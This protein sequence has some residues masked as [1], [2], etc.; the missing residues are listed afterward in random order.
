MRNTLAYN[1]I[2]ITLAASVISGCAYVDK[3]ATTRETAAELAYPPDGR[4][5]TVNGSKVHVIVTGSGPDLVLIHGA[6]GNT[7]DFTYEFVNRVKNDY[8]VI[9]FD[10]P[11][12][13]WT[14]R[15]PGAVGPFNTKFESP[16][17][18]ADLLH[19]AARQL[20]VKKPIVLGHSFGGA[21]ALAWALHHP[22]DTAALVLVSAV[23]NP[24]PGDLGALYTINASALGGATVV[25][26]IT[27]FAPDTM[28][29]GTIASIFAPQTAPDGYAQFVGAGLTVRRE[30]M[31]ANAQQVN[32][33]R[34]QIIEMSKHYG[35]LTMPVEIL[36]GTKDTIVPLDIHS[37][38]LSHQIAGA[39][40]TRLDGIGHMPHHAAPQAVVDA[41]DRAAHRAGLR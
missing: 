25:P 23:S 6:S 37:A 34:P 31:R 9:V 1:L 8:R 20:G 39:H 4:I 28:I 14:D 27:A 41:I 5:L 33:L 12:L 16:Y 38:P 40:L 15:L 13:G 19:A 3:R 26:L 24:W 2:T 21:V 11:G 22:E 30:S 32:N 18:Q 35:E 7:R 36:H 10:R 29:E 17:N